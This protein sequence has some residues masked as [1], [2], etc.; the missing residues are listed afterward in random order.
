MSLLTSS[1]FIRAYECLKED[2]IISVT[3]H[4]IDRR[5]NKSRMIVHVMFWDD[6]NNM[7]EKYVTLPIG[8]TEYVPDILCMWKFLRIRSYIV[9]SNKWNQPDE[10]AAEWGKLR[11]DSDF[12]AVITEAWNKYHDRQPDK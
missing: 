6:E 1:E 2:D 3:V 5:R 4:D 7:A 10:T 12:D 11:N 9:P 8:T